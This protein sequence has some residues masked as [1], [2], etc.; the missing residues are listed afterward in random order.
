MTITTDCSGSSILYHMA[1]VRHRRV[2]TKRM[3]QQMIRLYIGGT[4]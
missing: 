2:V 3:P 1:I 4:T